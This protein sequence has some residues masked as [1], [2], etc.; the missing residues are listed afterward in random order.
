MKSLICNSSP[1]QKVKKEMEFHVFFA[2]STKILLT[3]AWKL[4]CGLI[5]NIFPIDIVKIITFDGL[6]LALRVSETFPLIRNFD[7]YSFC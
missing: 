7:L 6:V 1:C 3:F 5:R 2:G 4:N